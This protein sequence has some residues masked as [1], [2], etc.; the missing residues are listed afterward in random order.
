MTLAIPQLLVRY[1]RGLTLRTALLMGLGVGCVAALG[2]RLWL[3]HA[4]P[5]MVC[6]IGLT[7]LGGLAWWQRRAFQQVWAA[8]AHASLALDRLLGLEARL[9]TA[10]Q[11]ANVSPPPPLYVRLMEDP[12]L[13]HSLSSVRLSPITDRRT[14]LLAV[15]LL[16]LL[17]WPWRANAPS[18]LAKL[19]PS[20]STP[21]E[22][23]P[24]TP[25]PTDQQ[26]QM[27]QQQSGS[28][29]QQQSGGSG[30]QPQ[31]PQQSQQQK[32]DGQPRQD[33]ADGRGQS[34]QQSAQQSQGDQQQHDKAKGQQSGQRAQDQAGQ[35]ASSQD[36]APSNQSG[37]QPK[38]GQ[39]RPSDSHG[40]GQENAGQRAVQA[41]SSG[42]QPLTAAQE[43]A[44]KADIQQ[45]L[46]QLSTEL[47]Q[48]QADLQ[49]QSAKQPAPPPG[50]STDPDLFED[51]SK[52]EPPTGG[53]LPIQLDVDTQPTSTARRGGGVGEPSDDAAEAPFQVQPESVD[54]AD[55]ATETPASQ[56][57]AIPPEY[58]PVFERLSR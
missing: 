21:P 16:A 41:M 27:S 30:E 7:A 49:Q 24:P 47:K 42:T 10:E 36:G 51:A 12:A 18:Q 14:L 43:E 40:R 2:W 11:F 50:T 55:S 9:I 15:V 48:L 22:I 38:T 29:Q 3:V 32:G 46:Q 39:S 53:A 54:L 31:S 52:L 25:P 34:G 37:A 56:R 28:Q 33:S 19:P 8:R 20:P 26:S 23:P 58:R 17:F 45:M 6:G 57:Q 35:P 1:R 4:H 13:V 44:I 5:L